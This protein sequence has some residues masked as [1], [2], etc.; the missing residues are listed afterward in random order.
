MAEKTLFKA[1]I[2][3]V[4]S[5]RD[6]DYDSEYFGIENVAEERLIEAEDREGV[7]EFLLDKYPQFFIGG[8]VYQRETKDK[9]QVFYVVIFPLYKW[10]IQTV[11]E[12]EWSC[13]QCEQVYSD[14]YQHK[15]RYTRKF[16][17]KDFCGNN[18]DLCLNNYVKEIYKDQDMPDN[19]AYINQDSPNYIYKITEKE[20]GKCYIGKTRNAPVW[21]WWA[22][23]TSSSSPFGLYI[24]KST[25]DKWA[26][27]VVEILSP[28]AKNEEVL[29]VESKYII[30]FDSINNGFN[31]VISNK[32][33][34]DEKI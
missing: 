6:K 32:S 20:S 7:K 31:S 22:H 19:I 23:L 26:F 10:E 3:I 30:K 34:L 12:G 33:V 15:P 25:L 21:R 18:N 17:G 16:E 2:R 29:K 5:K 27:E 28:T 11:K 9:K 14:K 4:K 24:Q 13:C 8:K 1:F